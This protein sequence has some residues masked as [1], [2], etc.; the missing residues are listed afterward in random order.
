MI[1]TFLTFTA[2]T[3]IVL[4]FNCIDFNCIIFMLQNSL[5]SK[6]TA[7]LPFIFKTS[8]SPYITHKQFSL[9]YK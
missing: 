9:I 3:F 1:Q 4:T 2:F 7:L 8:Q 6:P 5:H